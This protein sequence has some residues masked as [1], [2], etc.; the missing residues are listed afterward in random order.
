M[1][2]FVERRKNIIRRSG[3]NISAAEVENVLIGHPAVARVA[4]LS[5]ED[6]MR[7]EEVLCCIVPADGVTSVRETAG[8]IVAACQGRI[9]PYK[10]PGWVVFVDSLPM[11]STQKI[12]KSLIFPKGQDPRRHPCSFDMRDM[13]TRRPT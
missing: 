2:V 8:Q 7:D 11:T 10:W 12:Q 13:K 5:V 4:V 3:E 1:L 9:A 6:E